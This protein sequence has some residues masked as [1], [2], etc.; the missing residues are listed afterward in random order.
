MKRFAFIVAAAAATGAFAASAGEMAAFTD[1]DADG[2]G[3]VTEAEFVEYKA[4]DGDKT[5]AEASEKF[6]KVDADADGEVTEAEFDTAM[7]EWKDKK[8]A[9]VEVD[10]ETDT[11]SDW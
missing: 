7:E 9:D 3:A 4:A 8:D 1:I 11:G 5:E 6:M 2:D 10:V